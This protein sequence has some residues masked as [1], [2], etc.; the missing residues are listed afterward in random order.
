MT[1]V[2]LKSNCRMIHIFNRYMFYNGVAL[3]EVKKLYNS[4]YSKKELFFRFEK[5]YPV[6][7]YIDHLKTSATKVI[8]CMKFSYTNYPCIF[9]FY[10]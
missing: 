4:S 5:S 7:I 1:N 9:L 3:S 2:S 10:E 6:V 8:V